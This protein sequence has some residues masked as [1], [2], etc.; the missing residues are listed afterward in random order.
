[1]L[2]SVLVLTSESYKRGLV[3]QQGE[4]PRKRLDG[5]KHVTILKEEVN[6]GAIVVLFLSLFLVLVSLV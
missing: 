4:C 5:K 2:N 1:M 6:L 3:E